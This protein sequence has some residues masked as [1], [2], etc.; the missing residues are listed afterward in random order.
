MR[1][2]GVRECAA[3]TVARVGQYW[4]KRKRPN[5][6]SFACE[7]NDSKTIPMVCWRGIV[8]A[9]KLTCDLHR[10]HSLPEFSLGQPL[11]ERGPGLSV[12]IKSNR[13]ST[14]A[15]PAS[16]DRRLRFGLRGVRDAFGFPPGDHSSLPS[17]SIAPVLMSAMSLI[18]S[19]LIAIVPHASEP[20]VQRIIPLLTPS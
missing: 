14:D 15:C 19:S 9:L 7:T 2:P 1:S 20:R 4:S 3:G 10:L 6:G 11:S 8:Q 17:A 5:S 16:Q 12:S 18:S 13:Y